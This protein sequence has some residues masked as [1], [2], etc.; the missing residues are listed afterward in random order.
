M[1]KNGFSNGYVIGIVAIFVIVGVSS[2]LVF[3]KKKISSPLSSPSS[4][5]SDRLYET[6]VPKK[7]TVP[8]SAETPRIGSEDKPPVIKNLGIMLD[9]PNTQ[10]QR[11]GDLLFDRKVVWKDDGSFS[12]KAFGEFGELG[13]RRD[14]PNFPSVEYNFAVPIGTKVYAAGDGIARIFYIKHS[15]D[16]G[17]NIQPKVGSKWNIGQEHMINLLVKEGDVIKAGTILGEATPNRMG[18]ATTQLAVWTGGRDGIIKYCPFSFLEDNLKRD[19]KV[20]L[21]RIAEDW[22]KYIVQDVYRQENWVAPGCSLDKIQ[23]R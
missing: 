22:E 4:S 11:A 18:Y 23:E 9:T 21:E 14:A 20:I 5:S 3:Q 2:L 10:T 1:N 6:E 16:W 17:V 19:Y 13:K 12:D 8:Q 15:E 7:V